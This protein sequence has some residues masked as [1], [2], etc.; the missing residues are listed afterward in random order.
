MKY[1]IY[2]NNRVAK[3]FIYIFN[4]LSVI[5]LTDNINCIIELRKVEDVQVIICDFDKAIK[6]K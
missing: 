1:I 2:G 5:K 6:E 4:Q 3:D